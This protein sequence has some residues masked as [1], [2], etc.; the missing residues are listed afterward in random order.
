MSQDPSPKNTRPH[1][2]VPADDPATAAAASSGAA[3]LDA[4]PGDPPV[5]ITVWRTPAAASGI[6]AGL[7]G[8]QLAARLVAAY[9]R[10]G[11][12]VLDATTTNHP[13]DPGNAGD[14]G[15]PVL[16]GAAAAAGRTVRVPRRRGRGQRAEEPADGGDAGDAALAVCCWPLPRAG[17]IDPVIT[18]G[19]IRRRLRPGGV[20]AVI[21]PT[22][23]DGTG[24]AQLG[25]LVRAAAA[26][27]L[28]YLQHI[29]AMHATADGDTL[30][31]AT[32]DAEPAA[33]GAR[34]GGAAHLPAH[35][36][37]LVFTRPGFAR[38]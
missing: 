11:D 23:V 35:T 17:L 1:P 5:P 12:T 16:A 10:R 33:A 31:P 24:P 8:Q 29:V 26:A 13:G 22:P 14:A 2:P 27:G 7:I 30:V 37:V 19:G 25:P 28:G 6:G 38:A 21:V 34:A 18:L 20:L 32:G 3:D 4:V 36:D 15:D 9:T